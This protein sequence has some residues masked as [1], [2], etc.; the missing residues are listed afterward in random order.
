MTTESAFPPRYLG[1]GVYARFDGYYIWL[2]AER[3]GNKHAIAVEPP[4]LAALQKYQQDIVE[5]YN[6]REQR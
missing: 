2:E 5:F 1:D 3:E 6:A 4:V